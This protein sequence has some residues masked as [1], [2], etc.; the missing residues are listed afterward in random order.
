L[1]EAVE[2]FYHLLASGR[3]QSGPQLLPALDVLP[4][5]GMSP[6]AEICEQRAIGL[7]RLATRRVPV[8]IMPV[9]SALL[10]VESADFYRQL[11]LTLRVGDEV[12]LEDVV[13]HLDKRR[14]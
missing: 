2:T 9:A 13:A 4:M 5:Q 7:W 10:R 12:P 8:T 14:L 11:A 6:H 1:F 3:D